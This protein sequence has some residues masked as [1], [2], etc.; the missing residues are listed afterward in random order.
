ME[1]KLQRLLWSS[2]WFR[3]AKWRKFAEL[4]DAQLTLI[5]QPQ[6]GG[7]LHCIVPTFVS[8]NRQGDGQ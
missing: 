6:P 4:S 5:L 3:E 1:G 7:Y 8:R 2:W